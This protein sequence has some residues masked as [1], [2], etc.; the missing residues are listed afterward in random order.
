M[1]SP[2]SN[3][4]LLLVLG[5]A[6]LTGVALPFALR[7]FIPPGDETALVVRVI[8]GDTVELANGD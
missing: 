8:D 2:S 1:R 6:L 3:Q 4:R 7:P 5:S